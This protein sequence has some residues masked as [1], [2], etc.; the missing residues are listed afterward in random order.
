MGVPKYLRISTMKAELCSVGLWRD[1][2]A[3][4]LATFFLMAVQAALPLS[5]GK[6]GMG[7]PVQVGLGVGFIVATMAW[8]LGDFGGGHINPAVSIAMVCSGKITIVR[9]MHIAKCLILTNL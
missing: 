1:C 9:G 4:F 7:G 6:E 2:T 3:E 5:W 8:A